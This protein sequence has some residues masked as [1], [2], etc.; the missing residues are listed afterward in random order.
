MA[1]PFSVKHE[2][3]DQVLNWFIHMFLLWLIILNIKGLKKNTNSL[4][5]CYRYLIFHI[6]DLSVFTGI[7]T[8]ELNWNIWLST[9]F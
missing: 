2:T 5:S 8:E 6:M 7:V 9:T 3:K 1:L 4:D